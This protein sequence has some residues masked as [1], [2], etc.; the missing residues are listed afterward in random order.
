[1]HQETVNKDILVTGGSSGQATIS[2]VNNTVDQQAPEPA[3]LALLG[4]GLFG[5]AAM[6]RRKISR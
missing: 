4:A 3:T 5:L 1:M 2:F 6:R